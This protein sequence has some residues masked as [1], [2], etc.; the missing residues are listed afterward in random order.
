MRITQNNLRAHINKFV[1]KEQATFK[2]FLVNEYTSFGLDG[3]NKHNTQEIRGKSRPVMVIYRKH[4]TI[5][6]S[7]Y[8]I[9]F[10]R[11]NVYVISLKIQLDSQLLKFFRNNS[12]VFDT[13]IFDGYIALCHC[14]H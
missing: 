11:G 12:Q 9:H 5:E 10:L 14:S 6:I 4:A 2:H 3:N 7:S 8:L 13:R 1:N